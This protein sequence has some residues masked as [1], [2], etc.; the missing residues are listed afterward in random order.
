[1]SPGSDCLRLDQRVLLSE[2]R[3]AAVLLDLRTK[4]YFVLNATGSTVCKGLERG[5]C[6]P[7]LV[8]AICEAFAVS[9]EQ[10]ESDV[11]ALLKE[12]SNEGLLCAL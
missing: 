6:V 12:L 9:A 10:A 1:V 7:D 11:Q 2:F 4:R 5:A 8:A 3:D